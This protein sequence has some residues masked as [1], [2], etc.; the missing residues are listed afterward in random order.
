MIKTVKL[1]DMFLDETIYPRKD[2]NVDSKR[3]AR[4]VACLR[5]GEAFPPIKVDPQDTKYR[6]LDGLHRKKAYE[7]IGTTEIEVEIID[8][9]GQSPLL[10]AASCQDR[11]KNLGDADAQ[12]VA[13]RAFASDPKITNREI[14]KHVGRSEATISSYLKDLRAKHDMQQN[15]KIFKMA[16]LGIPQERIGERLGMPRQTVD[17]HLPKTSELKKSANDLLT[18][19]FSANT[20]ASKLGWP[21][22]LVWAVALEGKTDQE[23]FA[24]LKW[25][26]RPWD[27]WA[28][29]D[30][31]DRF[32]SEWPGRIPAQLIAHTLYFF[33]NPG[34]L[35]LDPMVGG[36]T[37]PD[38]CLALARQCWSFD[39]ENILERPEIEPFQWDHQHPIWPLNSK[40]KP[41]LIFF[42]PPYYKKK[43]KE[44]KEDSISTLARS[45]YL[46]FFTQ[47]ASLAIQNTKTTTR[48]AF[49]IA[50]WRDFQSK[51]AITEDPA[52][53]I[54]IF[55]YHKIL[56]AAGWELTHRIETPMSSERFKGNMIE[57][58]QK[59]RELGTV[60]RT[61][62]MFR[63][64]K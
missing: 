27:Y 25:N 55:D 29:N 22:P 10:F 37:T 43:E 50:D 31:D 20:V 18:K 17:E 45:E 38:V 19:G 4:Y 58:M 26:I 40:A 24:E 28:F 7:E 9:N 12:S 30:V 6:I 33:T 57:A 49:L 47:W 59:K 14:A 61:L 42:D 63:R 52:I 13:E 15:V 5:D 39:K 21:E 1:A 2:A 64:N 16:L 60:G 46:N 44:Y 8:L 3:V 53:A 54:T 62:L 36:G 34:D 48:L 11:G 23:R 51:A 35:I 41:D 56:S 32:G